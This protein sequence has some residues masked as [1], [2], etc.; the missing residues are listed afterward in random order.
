MRKSTILTSLKT[1]ASIG[2]HLHCISQLVL[3]LLISCCFVSFETSSNIS[4]EYSYIYLLYLF[5][6][7]VIRSVLRPQPT[8]CLR[9]RHCFKLKTQT[10]AQFSVKIRMLVVNQLRCCIK[11]K[12]LSICCSYFHHCVLNLKYHIVIINS[13]LKA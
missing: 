5:A 10:T 3:L 2:R 11:K 6:I 4:G 1:F 7:A 13:L 8:N 12:S 9:K